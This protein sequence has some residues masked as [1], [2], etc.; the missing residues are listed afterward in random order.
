[1]QLRVTIMSLGGRFGEDI[2]FHAATGRE[3]LLAIHLLD[4]FGC[5]EV[6][7]RGEISGGQIFKEPTHLSGTFSIKSARYLFEHLDNIGI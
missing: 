4:Q 6:S 7:L 1:M 5:D 3:A 2:T